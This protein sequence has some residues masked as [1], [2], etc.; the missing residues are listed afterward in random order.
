MHGF[1]VQ[2]KLVYPQLEIDLTHRA[3]LPIN[4]SFHYKFDKTYLRYILLVNYKLV[5]TRKNGSKKLLDSIKSHLK[6]QKQ[7]NSSGNLT[8]TFNS[9]S[10][11]VFH[12]VFKDLEFDKEKRLFLETD[13]E[14]L[15]RSTK[16]VFRWMNTQKATLS[17][18]G[19][20]S[21]GR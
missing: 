4:R 2:R 7:P 16:I 18:L 10:I 15:K 8:I 9:K 5:R 17:S 19:T 13:L 14:G 6:Q 11:D 20:S 21:T 12:S 1:R 3:A